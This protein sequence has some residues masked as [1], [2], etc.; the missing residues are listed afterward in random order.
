[1][2][3]KDNRFKKNKKNVTAMMEAY[4]KAQRRE[5]VEYQLN[6]EKERFQAR[7]ERAARINARNAARIAESSGRMEEAEIRDQAITSKKFRKL[8]KTSKERSFIINS[9]LP[10]GFV[11]NQPFIDFTPIKFD[12]VIIASSGGAQKIDV[13]NKFNKQ[14]SSI[15]EKQAELRSTINRIFFKDNDFVTRVEGMTYHPSSNTYTDM[16]TTL[17]MFSKAVSSGKD[18]PVMFSDT[19]T[20]GIGV[21]LQKNAMVNDFFGLTELSYSITQNGKTQ[22]NS[23]AFG[24]TTSEYDQINE[25][26]STLE[27]EDRVLSSDEN[28]LIGR[29]MKYSEAKFEK[30]ANG[31]H[32]VSSIGEGSSAGMTIAERVA[33]ARQGL[34]NIGGK[35]SILS[36]QRLDAKISK[37]FINQYMV[38][39]NGSIN[40]MF[41]GLNFD[42]KV[43]NMIATNLGIET[44]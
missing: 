44:G 33:V 10:K 34:E 43:M 23:M 21:D 8:S 29:L 25:L 40:T 35:N 39:A 12:P 27:K 15:S 31:T 30:N 9:S 42:S 24:M 22:R 37:D 18:V 6:K 28:V 1:M 26:L 13:P 14:L 32:Y 3:K 38:Q 4:E 11:D 19:E 5:E 17:K 16:N 7:A 20:L 36:S 2:A 41:N